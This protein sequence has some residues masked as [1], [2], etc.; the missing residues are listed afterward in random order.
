MYTATAISLKR[1]NKALADSAPNAQRLHS[2]KK[3]RQP[4][5]MMIVI[6]AM[7]YVCV[8]PYSSLHFFPYIHWKPSCA[9]IRLFYFWAF[10][11]YCSSAAVIPI[12]CL[13]F[14]ESYRRWLRNIL[15]SYC[16]KRDNMMSKRKQK[17]FIGKEKCS[18]WRELSTTFQWQLGKLRKNFGY[19]IIEILVFLIL[20][21]FNLNSGPTFISL[22]LGVKS[23]EIKVELGELWEGLSDFT[24]SKP[25]ILQAFQSHK[26]DIWY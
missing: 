20:R 14:A 11:A 19:S 8:I 15:C 10:F 17:N 23:L 2:L 13:S 7:F 22:S 26:F 18:A 24:Y 12:I 5:Q 6:V 25:I 9:F 3:R 21:K 16:G 4:I 1:Q